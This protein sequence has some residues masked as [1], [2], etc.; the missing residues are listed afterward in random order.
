MPA[1][2]S[3]MPMTYMHDGVQYIIMTI[4]A[5]NYPAALVALK[6]GEEEEAG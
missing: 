4:G 2:Q 1:A 6:L 3:G 5:G